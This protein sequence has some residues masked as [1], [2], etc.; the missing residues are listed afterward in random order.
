[1]HNWY[2]EKIKG[3]VISMIRSFFLVAVIAILG[4]II[5]FSLARSQG[6][7]NAM[8][9]AAMLLVGV[10]ITCSNLIINAIKQRTK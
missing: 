7:A 1:M 4:Y 2:G 10:I 5:C 9:F 6:I 3:G 8:S